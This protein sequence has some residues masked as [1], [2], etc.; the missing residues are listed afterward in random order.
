MTPYDQGYY[1]TLE[2]LGMNVPFEHIVASGQ[3]S[4]LNIPP[5]MRQLAQQAKQARTLRQLIAGGAIGGG[6]AGLGL[7]G[8]GIYR[9]LKE[10]D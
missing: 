6:L 9:A 4:G 8:Y 10:D 5:E 7:G 1:C 2:K 3:A